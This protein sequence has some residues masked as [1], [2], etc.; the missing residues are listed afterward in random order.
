MTVIDLTSDDVSGFKKSDFDMI[1]TQ[2]NGLDTSISIDALFN[3]VDNNITDFKN[4]IYKLNNERAI[5][6]GAYEIPTSSQKLIDLFS[7]I[8]GKN[9]TIK[10]NPFDIS[11]SSYD[12]KSFD[13]SSQGTFIYGLF[14]KSDGTKMYVV[15]HNAKTVYQYSLS[16]AWDVSTAS[17]DFKN[18]NASSI[19]GYPDKIFFK[20]DG[21][22][23]YLATNDDVIY[24][25][26]LSTAWEVSTA[27]SSYSLNVNSQGD[28]PYGLF[29]KSDGTKMYVISYND[30]K[31]YQYSLST[32]WNLSTA[33]Y[34]SKSFDVSS[35]STR[36]YGLFIK[37]DG[38]KMCVLSQN[39]RQIYQYSLS[40]AWDV[41]TANYDSKS[42]D[43][44]SQSSGPYELFIKSD[45][46]K[47]YVLGNNTVYQY[48]SLQ[49]F[50]DA[51]YDYTNQFYHCKSTSSTYENSYIT[52]IT[53]TTPSG[54]TKAFITPLL[55]EELAAGDSITADISLDGGTTYTTNIPINTWT[56][57]TSTDGTSLI[58][59]LNL[60]TGDGTTTP[61]VEGWSVLLE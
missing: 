4:N 55:H 32:A 3:G 8:G 18:F 40:T 43:V 38:T 29:F 25:Y 54:K 15:E 34:D 35:Q 14:F 19:G 30:V 37:S 2:I 27:T 21:T 41:S 58:A 24:Q 44:S 17:Y 10:Y 42:F 53:V 16:T 52:S 47:M 1:K 13:V 11:L 48:T 57:I 12:S 20:P 36:P 39:T 7:I 26:S 45:N 56:D 50:A 33:S 6:S 61:K 9:T 23:M 49:Y 51:T 60:N 31:I 22:I 46:S 28:N 5:I 59:K